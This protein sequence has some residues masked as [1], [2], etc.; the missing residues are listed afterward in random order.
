MTGRLTVIRRDPRSPRYFKPCDV[1]RIAQNCVDD[2]DIPPEV[3]IACVAKKLFVDAKVWIPDKKGY[4]EKGIP[5]QS[6][7]AAGFGT[8]GYEIMAFAE[9]GAFPAEWGLAGDIAEAIFALIRKLKMGGIVGAII[10]GLT[11]I[12]SAIMDFY[13]AIDRNIAVA[14]QDVL[15]KLPDSCDCDKKRTGKPPPPPIRGGRLTTST[16]PPRG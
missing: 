2:N 3:V 7:L 9:A 10:V 5:D 4:L 11:F 6:T 13:D 16:R 1:A 14:A 15:D 12:L 8:V